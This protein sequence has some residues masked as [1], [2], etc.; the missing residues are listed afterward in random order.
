[1]KGEVWREDG[2]HGAVYVVFP[3]NTKAEDAIKEAAQIRHMKKQDF[4]AV[5]GWTYKGSLYIGDGAPAKDAVQKIVVKRK[6]K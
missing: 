5:I 6:G 1:M 3:K 2:Y 4:I